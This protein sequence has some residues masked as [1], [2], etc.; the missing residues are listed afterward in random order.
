MTMTTVRL[1]A[2]AMRSQIFEDAQTSM[3]SRIFRAK[4]NEK[5]NLLFMR[6]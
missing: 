6:H 3:G 5:L 4:E 1:C 2:T